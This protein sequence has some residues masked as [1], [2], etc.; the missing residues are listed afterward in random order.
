M[1]V[2]TNPGPDQPTR[3]PW[4]KICQGAI[5]TNRRWNI[6]IYCL[7]I[8]NVAFRSANRQ[9]TSHHWQL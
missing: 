7:Y 8:Y 1:H 2:F 4:A 9:D 6:K 5:T 3:G